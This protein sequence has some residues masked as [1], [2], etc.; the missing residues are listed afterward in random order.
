MPLQSMLCID[1]HKLEA[2][3]LSAVRCTDY[4][5][6][7]IWHQCTHAAELDVVPEIHH[8]VAQVAG[9]LVV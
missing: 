1:E 6:Q 2:P 3:L 9:T 4:H 7:A 5:I 8:S